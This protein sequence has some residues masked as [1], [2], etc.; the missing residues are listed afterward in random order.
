MPP[1]PQD[2]GAE[3]PALQAPDL[4]GHACPQCLPGAGAQH[5]TLQTTLGSAPQAPSTP[6]QG[7]VSLW[8]RKVAP[9][10]IPGAAPSLG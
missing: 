5:P 7:G 8:S 10:S 4:C 6:A 2:K 1:Q 3:T 9:T